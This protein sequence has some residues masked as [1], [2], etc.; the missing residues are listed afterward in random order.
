MKFSDG[1]FVIEETIAEDV[2]RLIR[3]I[4]DNCFADGPEGVHAARVRSLAREGESLAFFKYEIP[5][6]R[7]AAT[8]LLATGGHEAMERVD[9]ANSETAYDLPALG[10]GF[11]PSALTHVMTDFTIDDKT[12]ELAD[13]SRTAEKLLSAT[14]SE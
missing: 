14:E 12:K 11:D 1:V 13:F 7:G 8:T 5:L 3:H 6:L 10:A 4:A 9:R 2:R